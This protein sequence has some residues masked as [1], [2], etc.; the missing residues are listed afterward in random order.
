MP[1]KRT[2]IR[3]SANLIRGGPDRERFDKRLAKRCE[4]ERN[5]TEVEAQVS[6]V[7]M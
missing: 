6:N 7:E 3:V 1:P 5:L 4:L 2:S